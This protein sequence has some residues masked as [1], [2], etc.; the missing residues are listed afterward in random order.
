MSDNTPRELGWEDEI[1][2]ESN[3]VLLPPGDYNFEV[4]KFER[5]ERFEGSE[6]HPPCNRAIVHIKCVSSGGDETVIQQSFL[7]HQ[8]SEW[9]I[10]EF[11]I[12]IGLKKHGEPLRMQWTQSVGCKGRC[13]LGTRQYD[14]KDY[15]EIK[16]FYDPEEQPRQNNSGE[17]PWGGGW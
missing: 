3:F 17:T 2:Q 13:K 10:S 8:K 12:S 1:S 14:S 6:K 9:R 7:M 15:N 16:K 11:F 5:G 4:V